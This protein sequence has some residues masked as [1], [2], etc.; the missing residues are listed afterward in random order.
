MIPKIKLQSV[1]LDCGQPAQLAKFYSDLLGGKI[2]FEI[3]YFVSISIP[4]E[5]ITI[6][7]QFDEDY[8]P[9]A[10]PGSREEQMKMEHLDFSVEDMEA[11]V[12]YAISLGAAKAPVQYWQPEYGAQWVTL[13][14]PA[15][16]PFCLCAHGDGVNE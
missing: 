4:G 15:G 13:L 11:S 1:V 14:D 5:N 6:S 12:Q 9:P 10:W 3:E 16:H 2:V 7:C 8:I